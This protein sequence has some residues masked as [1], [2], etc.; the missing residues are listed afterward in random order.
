RRSATPYTVEG[1][2]CA[3]PLVIHH[4]TPAA[5]SQPERRAQALRARADQIAG[6]LQSRAHR[7]AGRPVEPS[8]IAVLL[9]TARNITALRDELRARGVPCVT[10]TRSSVFATDIARDLQTVL[11]AVAY[12]GELGALR[13]AA[14]TRL[15]GTSFSELQEWG[16]DV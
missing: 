5:P 12:P 1:D 7:I 3:K 4:Q 8:D 10:S 14:A 15:W 16:D 6:M 13:A 2:P 11:Y 9:P